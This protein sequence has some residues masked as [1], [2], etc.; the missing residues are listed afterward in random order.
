MSGAAENSM[1]K[2]V[3]LD[4]ESRAEMKKQAGAR[5][6]ST[7]KGD[8][9]AP[10][11]SGNRHDVEKGEG[12]KPDNPKTGPKSDSESDPRSSQS[13]SAASYGKSEASATWKRSAPS[14]QD[15][16]S[17]IQIGGKIIL[18][19]IQKRYRD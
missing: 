11:E 12:S 5:L 13:P 6:E 19:R 18:L 14:T 7:R 8:K 3:G 17:G 15:K 10:L 16:T 2:K 4:T 9:K 1:P